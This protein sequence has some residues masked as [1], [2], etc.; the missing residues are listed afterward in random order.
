MPDISWVCSLPGTLS[1][2]LDTFSHVILMVNLQIRYIV[3]I[4]KRSVV[5]MQFITQIGT[6]WGVKVTILCW[7]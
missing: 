1:H 4:V 7:K 5:I 6:F 3:P 2:N